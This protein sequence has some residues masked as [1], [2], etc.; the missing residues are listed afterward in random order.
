[1]L[2]FDIWTDVEHR[3]LLFRVRAPTST[4]IGTVGVRKGY[5]DLQSLVTN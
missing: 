1:M 4:A 2:S 5:D 3:P